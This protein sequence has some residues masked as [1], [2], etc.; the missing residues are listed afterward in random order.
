CPTAATLAA[1]AGC[2]LLGSAA[3][4]AAPSPFSD[5]AALRSVTFIDADRGWCVGDFGVILRSED[6]GLSWQPLDSSTTANLNA[7]GMFNSRRGLVVGGAYE[8]HTQLGRGTVLLTDD[9]GETWRPA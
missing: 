6:S 8:P 2:W 4:T 7:V 3:A 5:E 1:L 9:G